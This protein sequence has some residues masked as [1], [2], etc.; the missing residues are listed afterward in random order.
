SMGGGGSIFESFFGFDSEEN[1][2]RQGASKKIS[3]TVSF[4]EAIK[5]AEKQIAITN[6]ITCDPCS[7][8]GA[9]SSKDIKT[10]STCSGSGQVFQTRG[11]FSM[12]S[13]CSHC[14]GEGKII[15]N[16]CS[17]CRGQ[18]RVRKKQNVKIHIPAGV[19]NNM[20]LKMTGYGDASEGGGPAGDLYV[21]ITVS[22]HDSFERDGDDVYLRLPITF[23]EASLGCKKEIP[24]PEGKAYRISIPEGAQNGKT[25]RIRDL[26]FPN[27]HGAGKGDLLVNI[28]VETPVN[29]SSKQVELLKNF[30][31]LETD[32]NH[33][34][35]KSFFDKVK[36]FFKG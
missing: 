18:G 14:R 6:Y 7:G 12:A 5:G 21:F 30:Q 24:T 10:C 31:N 13:T 3:I 34:K 35:K 8:S 15:T 16:P 4:E 11:F 22:P 2:L 20:R 26:G 32:E 28:S 1:S 36:S 33:P 27:V 23:T 9:K 19:D 17:T 29:L 25:F